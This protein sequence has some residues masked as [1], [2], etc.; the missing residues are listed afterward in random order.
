MKR[1]VMCGAAFA[2]GCLL[3]LD[4]A[5]AHCEAR[6][7]EHTIRAGDNL[8]LIAGYYY[9][10]PRQWKKIWKSNRKK[11]AGPDRLTPGKI[12][13]IEGS[14]GEGWQGTY[15]DFLSRVRGN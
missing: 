4:P 9:G 1:M 8:H 2:V 7:V 6:A 10:D 12:V 11:V 3:C 13:L 15:E 14:S 5:P